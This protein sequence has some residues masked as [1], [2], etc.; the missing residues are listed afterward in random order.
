MEGR[1]MNNR[2]SPEEAQEIMA[3]GKSAA[4]LNEAFARREEA[5]GET[6]ES[7]VLVGESL[8]SIMDSV[9]PPLRWIVHEAVPVGLTLL[10][11]PA[12]VGK[13]FMALDMALSVAQGEPWMRRRT[14]QGR[15]LYLALEDGGRRIQDRARKMLAGR[16]P[17][18]SLIFV[19]QG[20]TEWVDRYGGDLG[21]TLER[22][23]EDC[24][25]FDFVIIDTLSRAFPSA[26]QD[27]QLEMQSVL[28][29][30]Q[31]SG[32]AVL[33]ID[34]TKKGGGA[35]HRDELHDVQW[36]EQ[37]AGSRAKG[38]TVDA[39]LGMVK[40][41]GLDEEDSPED[42]FVLGASLRDADSWTET[43]SRCRETMRFERS[44]LPPK[45]EGGKRERTSEID[46]WLLTLLS[47]GE[48]LSKE[49][50]AK[51]E[52]EGYTEKRLEGAYTRLHVQSRRDGFG[53][54]MKSYWR[55]PEQVEPSY[56]SPSTP[57]VPFTPL[58]PLQEKQGD[59]RD[60][61]T[62]GGRMTETKPLRPEVAP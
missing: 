9:Y 35:V 1:S 6:A 26:D 3:S 49:V 8:P 25:A 62:K 43:I 33:L 14:T 20:T 38:A 16:T 12:K 19:H 28:A 15:V 44:E 55:L 60:E 34:H 5:T 61:W 22:F 30:L 39:A 58:F 51:A 2:I 32:R 54:E 31:A 24:K 53:K 10:S 17:P 7:V 4:E 18:D 11:G 27:K 21:G 48:V 29:P 13:S 47:F 56:S 23:I 45:S 37:A 59:E 41:R 57:F 40:V 50:K 46:G 52:E 36:I 42:L